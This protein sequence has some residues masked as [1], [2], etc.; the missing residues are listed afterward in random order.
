MIVSSLTDPHRLFLTA[1]N[2]NHR[3]SAA[4]YSFVNNNPSKTPFAGIVP[5]AGGPLGGFTSV[6]VLSEGIEP[7]LATAV[8][9]VI[10]S[11][12]FFVLST[13]P[14]SFLPTPS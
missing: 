5:R 2:T 14:L 8:W 1:F 10:H 6:L 3:S 7:S 9:S 13:P 4:E 11:F 12:P